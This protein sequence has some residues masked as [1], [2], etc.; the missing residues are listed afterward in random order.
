MSTLIDLSP[1]LSPALP[2]WPGDRPFERL[3]SARMADGADVELSAISTSLHLGAHVDAPSH[4]LAGA[5]TL[6]ELPLDL[7]VGPCEVIQLRPPSRGR[8]WPEQLPHCP[9]APRVLFGT[10]TWPDRSTFTEEFAA[11]SV[12]LID[13]LDRQGVRL[14]GIDTPSVDLFAARRL[15]VHL[16]LA[17]RG[18]VA[19]E[20]LNL[21]G[22]ES[23]LYTLTA[24]PLRIEGADG[25]PVR[26]VLSPA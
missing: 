12:E 26:A 11:L 16:A 24:L 19:L 1:T 2:V 15:D 13:Y 25:C 8:L 3:S 6:D 5:P 17:E 14:V 20:G 23:G 18:M 7:F 10:G 9:R 4:A 21:D 22:V